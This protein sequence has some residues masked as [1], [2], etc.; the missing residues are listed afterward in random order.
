MFDIYVQ[1]KCLRHVKGSFAVCIL[2][3][4]GVPVLS[5]IFELVKKV[6]FLVEKSTGQV[7]RLIE[8]WPNEIRA[9]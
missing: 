3:G 2:P 7:G 6:H 5:A 8:V 1:N 9:E 4:I